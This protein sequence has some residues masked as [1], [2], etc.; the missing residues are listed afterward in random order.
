[1][2]F[3][4]EELTL[5]N[6]KKI[7]FFSYKANFPLKIFKEEIPSVL[8]EEFFEKNW[9]SVFTGLSSI[10]GPENSNKFEE[11]KSK[12]NVD[13]GTTT[14]P[15]SLKDGIERA[16]SESEQIKTQ[17][18]ELTKDLDLSYKDI[19]MDEVELLNKILFELYKNKERFSKVIEFVEKHF[20]EQGATGT[21]SILRKYNAFPKILFKWEEKRKAQYSEYFKFVKTPGFSTNLSFIDTKEYRKLPEMFKGTILISEI[22]HPIYTRNIEDLYYVSEKNV[23]AIL[24]LLKDYIEPEIL[25]IQATRVAK[26]KEIFND[27][28][29]D[30]KTYLNVFENFAKNTKNELIKD[31][32]YRILLF[33]AVLTEITESFIP[34]GKGSIYYILNTFYLSLYDAI[35]LKGKSYHEISQ[36]FLSRE[37]RFNVYKNV[38][39]TSRSLFSDLQGFVKLLKN[40]Y[41]QQVDLLEFCVFWNKYI[42]ISSIVTPVTLASEFE[43]LDM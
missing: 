31:F 11:T 33:P 6:G 5:P 43:A 10:R 19:P 4:K 8:P 9:I 12:E 3:E 26:T 35:N 42:S 21:I 28:T 17:L 39:K 20:K 14:D 30:Y 41:Q 23:D 36:Y 24:A 40:K 15:D 27:L 25:D 18:K 1:M 29:K 32:V 7:T 16:K 2:S 37:E 13:D 38:L 22:E 34:I